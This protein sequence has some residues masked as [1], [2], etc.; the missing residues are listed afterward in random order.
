MTV[1]SVGSAFFYGL[2]RIEAVGE[3]PKP[4]SEKP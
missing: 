3:I 1:A 2:E 4:P